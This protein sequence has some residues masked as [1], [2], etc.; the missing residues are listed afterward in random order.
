MIKYSVIIP[1]YNSE[2]TLAR[3]LDSLLAQNRGDVEIVV[4]NDGSTDGSRGL[5]LDYVAKYPTVVCIHQE[6]AGVSCARNTGIRHAK[7]DYITF[8]DSDDYVT[9]DYFSVLDQTGD[10]DLLVFAHEAVG[11]EPLDETELFASLQNLETSGKR[12]E[13]LLSS[14]K[15]M[16]PC[17]KRFKR[18]I[19]QEN[20]LQFIRGLSVGE[21]FNFCTA[22]AMHCRSIEVTQKRILCIDISDQGSLSRR[23]RPH[24]DDQLV[25]V[26]EHVANTIRSNTVHAEHTQR[27]MEIMDYLYVKH[28]FSCISEEFKNQKMNYL[29]D[30][31]KIANICN[32]F[33]QPLSKTR[34]NLIHR[35]LRLALK[36]RMYYPFYLVCYWVKGRRYSN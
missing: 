7:G 25:T 9:Q 35:A 5:L 23:Y 17:N 10:C 29:R 16:S 15:I 3:C 34:C 33:R 22:Y 32:K 2:K 27:L 18:S 11:G 28:I 30:R 13:L 8:L 26:F 19:V 6:N 20:G 36:W 12:L 4:V 31:R 24:L 14:R 1:V 21:D